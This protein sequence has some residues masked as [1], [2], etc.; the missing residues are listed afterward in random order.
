VVVDHYG[1]LGRLAAG[2][3]ASVAGLARATEAFA[4]HYPTM[5]AAL[6][7]TGEGLDRLTAGQAELQRALAR[8][9]GELASALEKLEL[10]GRWV[11][12]GVASLVQTAGHL[13]DTAQVLED[14]GKRTAD[15]GEAFLGALQGE[16]EAQTV[17]AEE[18][19][20][21]A[22]ALRQSMGQVRYYADEVAA[23]RGDLQGLRQ[24]V[25]GLTA[26]L[27]QAASALW[28]QAERGNGRSDGP[29]GWR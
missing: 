4:A 7:R 17:I 6:E 29:P 19:A 18:V 24:V 28:T 10:A 21:A 14:G 3:Q 16:R 9:E 27:Q 8:R 13:K 23:L 20:Q 2:L 22:E 1:E 5:S 11:G 25:P 26:A 12:N 15:R